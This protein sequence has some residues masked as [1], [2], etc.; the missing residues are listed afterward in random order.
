MTF[1][2][3][4]AGTSIVVTPVHMRSKGVVIRVR[5]RATVEPTCD[6]RTGINCVHFVH[7]RQKGE[8]PCR[9]ERAHITEKVRSSHVYT[10][11]RLRV[12]ESPSGEAGGI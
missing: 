7:V 8:V 2:L 4:I 1:M 3:P 10:G 11:V 9:S 5:R 12:D 6:F